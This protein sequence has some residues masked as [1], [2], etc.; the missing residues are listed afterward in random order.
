MLIRDFE[1]GDLRI[2]E[3]TPLM[4]AC[5][6][7]NM[8]TVEKIVTVAR[9]TLDPQYFELFIN[10]KVE[11]Q[12]GGNNAL[13]Y[14][15]NSKNKESFMLVNYLIMEAGANCNIFNDFKRNSLLIAARRN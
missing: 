15:I 4:V 8:K 3:L 14:A 6:M 10:V 13:L 12:Q 2:K 9:E 5:I 11:R 7:G 1:S